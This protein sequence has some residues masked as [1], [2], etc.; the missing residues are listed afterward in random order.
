MLL[1][2]KLLLLYASGPNRDQ[3]VEAGMNRLRVIAVCYFL[4]GLMEVGCGIL[5]GMGR[6][7]QPM[8]VSLLGSC[9]FRIVWVWTVCPLFPG[10]IMSLY[11]SYPIS[12][13]VTGG[14]HYLF[15]FYF[16]RRLIKRKT[17]REAEAS[18]PVAQ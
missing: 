3:I 11:I 16:Y 2:D 6:A 18:A 10:Q 13:I 5:R 17:E 7:M 12:W 4:C 15:C 1:G 8:V 14:A 9:L